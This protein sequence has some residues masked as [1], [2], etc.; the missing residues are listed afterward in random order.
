MELKFL[1]FALAASLVGT[2]A[3]A[4]DYSW[5]K[6]SNLEWVCNLKT[7]EKCQGHEAN[8][9]SPIATNRPQFLAAAPTE[10]AQKFN[11]THVIN[12]G[13]QECQGVEWQTKHMGWVPQGNAQVLTKWTENH[14]GTGCRTV[15]KVLETVKKPTWMLIFVRDGKVAG[16]S[17]YAGNERQPLAVYGNPDHFGTKY[18]DFNAACLVPP[19]ETVTYP[20]GSRL[21]PSDRWDRVVGAHGYVN[22]A[23]GE[24]VPVT[25]LFLANRG[26]YIRNT[27]GMGVG[28]QVALFKKDRA[29]NVTR[30]LK[31]ACHVYRLD[32]RYAPEFMEKYTVRTQEVEKPGSGLRIQ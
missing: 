23:T 26:T 3:V 19:Q 15:G 6:T 20:D 10:E 25:E 7:Q 31:P 16:V 1:P 28:Q 2:P 9:Y 30:W 29:A 27:R 14:S 18:T 32:L 21:V 8:S 12:P 11:Y 24:R 5:A 22:V 13:R 17:T 4:A